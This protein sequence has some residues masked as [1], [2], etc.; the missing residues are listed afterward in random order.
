MYKET[1]TDMAE[2]KT[3]REGNAEIAIR[4]IIV[5]VVDVR[6]VRVEVIDDDEI[7]IQGSALLLHFFIQSQDKRRKAGFLYKCVS[8]MTA[9]AA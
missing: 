1:S 4:I 5:P 2:A 6:S 3:S 9:Q 7:T 8:S